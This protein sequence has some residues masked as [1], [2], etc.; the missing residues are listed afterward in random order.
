MS[1][2]TTQDPP[3]TGVRDDIPVVEVRNVTVRFSGLVALDDIS[4][5]V[6][7]GTIHAV[8]GPNGAGKSTCFNVISGVYAA[9]EGS[10]HF[11]DHAL[12]SMLPNKIADAGVARTFQNIALAKHSSVLENIMLGRHHLTRSGFL[13]AGLRLPSAVREQRRHRERASEIAEFVGLGDKQHALAGVMSYG[14]QK[15]LEMARA[16]A[17]EPKLLMLDE[18]VAGMNAAETAVMAE[19]ISSVQQALGISILLVEHDMGMV[20]KLADHV[21]VLD[22]GKLIADGEPAAVQKDPEVIRAYLGGADELAKR[23]RAAHRDRATDSETDPTAD[24]GTDPGTD[25]DAPSHSSS[26]ST[27]GSP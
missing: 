17:M 19:T 8:I 16:L 6:Q 23:S 18:P 15:R 13:S 1:A 9:T 24:P 22:F 10:V 21:T 25:P 3:A 7:P 20:M 2:A 26:T 4:F 27:E 14:D 5:T 12:T 11:G